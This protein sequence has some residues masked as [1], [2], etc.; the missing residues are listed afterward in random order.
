MVDAA[1]KLLRERGHGGVT[2]RQVARTA[3]VAPATAYTYFSSKDHLIAEV[4]WRRLK[5]TPPGRVTPA[6]PVAARVAAALEPVALM[7]VEESPV[8]RAVTTAMLGADPEIPRVRDRI[9]VALRR[10]ISDAVAAGDDHVDDTAVQVLDLVISGALLQAGIGHLPYAE[11][12]CVLA[13]ATTH[14]LS[15]RS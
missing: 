7:L 12:P 11:L 1:E 9:G 6:E 4:F 5:D 14:V 15:S 8:A 13:N 3:G 2:M 10:R